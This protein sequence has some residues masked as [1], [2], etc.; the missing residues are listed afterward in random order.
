MMDPLALHRMMWSMMYVWSHGSIKNILILEY[1]IQLTVQQDLEGMASCNA[2]GAP[3]R[4]C[5][6]ALRG[7]VICDAQAVWQ[8][9]CK[10]QSGRCLL[11]HH[12]H[13]LQCRLQH[14]QPALGMHSFSYALQ[15]QRKAGHV[16]STSTD[17]KGHNHHVAAFKS[18]REPR[19]AHVQG[20][21]DA[22][23]I[24]GYKA[25]G[26]PLSIQGDSIG[27]TEDGAGPAP[28]DHKLDKHRSAV[29]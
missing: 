21:V 10:V 24:Q 8:G 27:T 7:V 3:A 11:T 18:G 29:V 17:M 1:S 6:V 20:A 2:V 13:A 16:P 25:W 23:G 12:L 14:G 26:L 15:L 4:T 5:G 19:D 9:V 22:H 28:Q